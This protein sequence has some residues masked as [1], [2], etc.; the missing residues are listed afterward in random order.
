[1]TILRSLAG[2]TEWSSS[3]SDHI[4]QTDYSTD[5]PSLTDMALLMTAII[6]SNTVSN[7]L[8]LQAIILMLHVASLSGSMGVKHEGAPT[9]A[10]QGIESPK[11]DQNYN[12]RGAD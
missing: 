8:G 4:R 12:G 1:M 2:L 7:T 5:P 11:S 3:E 9:S 10:V 6:I